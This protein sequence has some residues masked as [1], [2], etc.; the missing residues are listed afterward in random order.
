[1]FRRKQN[2]PSAPLFHPE[3]IDLVALS[4]NE[5]TVELVIVADRGWSGSDEQI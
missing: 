5:T 4:P 3:K 1:M 2:E